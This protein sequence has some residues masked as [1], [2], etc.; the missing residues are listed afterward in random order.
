LRIAGAAQEASNGNR[1]RHTHKPARWS[2]DSTSELEF[3]IRITVSNLLKEYKK[4]LIVTMGGSY[5]AAGSVV[6]ILNLSA[7]PGCRSHSDCPT[8][9]PVVLICAHGAEV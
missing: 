8:K 9:S 7:K 5:V 4:L 3:I 6:F 2:L 1:A